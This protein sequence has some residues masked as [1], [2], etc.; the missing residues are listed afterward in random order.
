MVP[1]KHSPI[2]K[3]VAWY[4]LIAALQISSSGCAMASAKAQALY[5]R[6]VYEYNTKRTKHTALSDINEAVALDVKNPL[7]LRLKATILLDMDETERAMLCIEKSLQLDPK[8]ADAW[9]VKA[10]ILNELSKSN[11]AIEAINKSIN[12]SPFEGNCVAKA[13]ILTHMQKFAEAEKEMDDFLKRMPT[14]MLARGRRIVAARHLKHWNKEIEDLNFLISTG[15]SKYLSYDTHLQ[16][17]AEAYFEL[18]QYDKAKADYKAGLKLSP[19]NRLLHNGLLK[20]YKATG[21][22]MGALAESK[23]LENLDG[24]IRPFK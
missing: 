13:E 10:R 19:D 1:Y 16:E 20:I 12:L 24:D 2:C 11:Q 7:Y 21:N 15:N 6:A 5:L 4:L 8:S 17:R 23:A 3:A 9:L 22:T 18:K 14:S